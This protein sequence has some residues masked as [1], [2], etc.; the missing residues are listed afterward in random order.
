MEPTDTETDSAIGSANAESTAEP[1]P[2]P[3]SKTANSGHSQMYN[4]FMQRCQVGNRLVPQFAIMIAAFI[5]AAGIAY[6]AFMLYKNVIEPNLQQQSVQQE[7][8]TE[9]P[10]KDERAVEEVV[11]TLEAKS[12][13]VSA[14]VD[15]MLEQG[16]RRDMEWSYPQL[17]S[18]TKDDV[19][20]KI[21]K[22][23]LEPLQIDAE[24]TNRASDNEQ[25]DAE[26]YPDGEFPCISR[27][28]TVTYMDENFFCIR[29]ERYSTGWG[30]H[31]G[32]VVTGVIFDLHTGDTVSPQDMFG[33]DTEDL[34][35][36]M[37]SAVWPYLTE[38]GR[39]HPSD[40]NSMLMRSNSSDYSIKGST[41]LCVT[42]KGLVYH[43]EDYE[44]GSFADGNCEILV[45]SWDDEFQVGSE[46]TPDEVKDGTTV[47]VDKED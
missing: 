9:R 20:D 22:A 1:S 8:A 34:A 26:L 19:A 29:D 11:Y 13:T 24:R 7:Q 41:C 25:S 16:E 45:A 32:T 39:E 33:I 30:P 42:S 23:I 46:V 27:N 43:T 44:L 36:S 28:V 12:L 38:M 37:S 10:K 2:E 3:V 40:Y 31:G 15:P 47:K 6:A 14:P 35:S 5:A 4:F 21:N 17:K 18:S